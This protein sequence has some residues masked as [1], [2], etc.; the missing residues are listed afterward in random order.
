MELFHPLSSGLAKLKPKAITG[1]WYG[2][3]SW[4]LPWAK[5]LLEEKS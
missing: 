3:F 5:V 2:T 4:V 1:A